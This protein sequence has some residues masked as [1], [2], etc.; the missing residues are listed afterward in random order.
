MKEKSSMLRL[1]NK[2]PALAVLMTRDQCRAARTLLHMTQPQLARRAGCS[3][4]TLVNY[5]LN[6][7]Y[8]TDETIQVIS[9]ALEMA[10]IIFIDGNGVRL[11][12]TKG[13]KPK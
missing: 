10:G 6:R 2:I 3:L 8:V 12:P 9:R 11:N 5:E 13:R 4:T 1:E 7:R